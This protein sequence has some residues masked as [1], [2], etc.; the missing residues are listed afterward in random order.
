MISFCI[1]GGPVDM[2]NVGFYYKIFIKKYDYHYIIVIIYTWRPSGP[3]PC[4]FQGG[5]EREERR[6]RTGVINHFIDYIYT[7]IN[8][9]EIIYV[10]KYKS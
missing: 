5:Q 7:Y 3:D 8:H 1:P 9:I 2:A 10:C 4:G 6:G